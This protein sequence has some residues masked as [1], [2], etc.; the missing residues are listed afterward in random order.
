MKKI[1]ATLLIPLAVAACQALPMPEG[2]G[3]LRY[4]K[5]TKMEYVGADTRQQR[6]TVR[7]GD[8]TMVETVQD[9][10]PTIGVGDVVRVLGTGTNI[11]VIRL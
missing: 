2:P 1:L 11:K 7:L 9:R 4:G 5:I 6:V 3:D 10:D 8:G